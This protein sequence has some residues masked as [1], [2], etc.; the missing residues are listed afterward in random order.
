MFL[1]VGLW[2]IASGKISLLCIVTVSDTPSPVCQDGCQ[3]CSPSP[4]PG[5]QEPS[6]L[7]EDSA[8]RLAGPALQHAG[9]L[10][11]GVQGAAG[12]GQAVCHEAAARAAGGAPGAVLGVRSA[13]QCHVP[14]C[15]VQLG[16]PLLCQGFSAV[17]GDPHFTEVLKN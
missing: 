10:P 1:L 4:V 8:R 7:P 12:P 2:N 11:G 14:G 5:V 16:H 3:G 9:D 15:R 6:R 13:I 17:A